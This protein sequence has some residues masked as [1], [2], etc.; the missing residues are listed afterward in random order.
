MTTTRKATWLRRLGWSLLAVLA[1]VLLLLFGARWWLLQTASGA[2][3][4]LDQAQRALQPA[5]QIERSTGNINQ[6]LRLSGVQFSNDISNTNIEQIELQARLRLLPTPQ[7]TIQQLHV[8][9]VQ[10]TVLPSDEPPPQTLPDL[11]SPIAVMVRDLRLRDVSVRLPDQNDQAEP[12]RLDSLSAALDYGDSLTVQ[13]LQLQAYAAELTVRGDAELQPPYSHDLRLDVQGAGKQ[14]LPELHDAALELRSRG[15]LEDLA[16][17]VQGRDGLPLRADVKL[18]QI[19]QQPRWELQIDSSDTLRWPLINA[20]PDATEKAAENVTDMPPLALQQ[21]QFSSSGSLDD[22][23]AELRSTVQLPIQVAGDWQIKLSGDRTQLQLESLQGSLMRGEVQAQGSYQLDPPLQ[24]GELQLQ[25]SRLQLAG[26]LDENELATALPPVSGS[27]Y[28][29]LAEQQLRLQDLLLQAADLP[30]QLRADASYGLDDDSIAS[31][32][33]WQALDWPPGS[34]ERADWHSEQGQLSASG[35]LQDLQ[36][37]LNSDV[38]G[39]AIPSAQLSLQASLVQLQSL[40]LQQLIMQT[41]GGE[42]RLSGTAGWGDGVQAQLDYQLQNIDPGQFWAGYQGNITS[43]GSLKASANADFSAPQA[44]VAINDLSG[45]LRGQPISGQGTLRYADQQFISEGLQLQSGEAKLNLHGDEKALQMMLDIPSAG[46]L[47]AAAAGS[48]KA[49][50]T[51]QALPGERL[52]LDR[53]LLQLQLSGTGLG[54]QQQN[55]EA[56]SMDADLILADAGLRGDA[57]ITLKELSNRSTKLLREASLQ[58]VSDGDGQ[59]LELSA[60]RAGTSLGLELAGSSTGP[61]GFVPWRNDFAWQGRLHDMQLQDRQLGL[62]QQATAASISYIANLL[63]LQPACLQGSDDNA[64]SSLCISSELA[65]AGPGKPF[66]IQAGLDIEQLPVAL[67]TRL[68][69]AAIT[70]NQRMSGSIKLAMA[71]QL[72]QLDASLSLEPGRL[73]LGGDSELGLSLEQG[74]LQLALT[75]DTRNGDM[76]VR[77]E[78]DGEIN[79]NWS[80]GPLPDEQPQ[81]KGDLRTRLPDL[82]LLA[83]FVPVLNE[84]AGSLNMHAQFEGP[85]PQPLIALDIDLRDGRIVYAPVGLALRDINLQGQSD[86]GQPFRGQGGLRAGDGQASMQFSLAPLKRTAELSIQGDSLQLADSQVLQLKVSPNLSLSAAPEGFTI[87]GELLIPSALLQPPKQVTSQQG[88]SADVVIVGAEQPI[89]EEQ[90][91]TNLNGKLKLVLGDD[92]RVKADVASTRLQGAV[93][94]L[95]DGEPIPQADGSIELIDGKIEAYG[96]TL[97]LRDSRVSYNESPADNPRLDIYA[98]R[99]IFGDPAVSEAGV[100]VTGRAQQPDIRLFT[101]PASNEESALAYIA[102]GSNF[103]HGNGEGA[104]N[105]GLYLFPRLFVSYGVGLFD[106]GNVTNA[107][108]ELSESWNVTLESGQRDSAVQINWRKNK[109]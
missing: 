89:A 35:T 34:G 15:D 74:E 80:Y 92:V 43:S 91:Q 7:L 77:F 13:Q 6:G 61:S 66:S 69:D 32:L 99:R 36:L 12:L 63:K 48:L 49:D 86:P 27:A 8:D 73:L 93:S 64:G 94:L 72:E 50:I 19:M 62:W 25:L 71:E 38:S 101:N 57:D 4:I 18:Y 109:D 9:G 76:L 59:R 2:G 21:L 40:Q 75:E 102:T 68:T 108:Y 105:L 45:S 10:V 104:L 26:M 30:W 37:N 46:Q 52:R 11:R 33:H 56:V 53:G 28:L 100:A 55:L 17:Q 5:L 41:L 106:N 65:S 78:Q 85:L 82:S 95:W 20:T 29:R 39:S 97:N 84:L 16:L 44:T 81:L 67:L 87:D 47:Y 31:S 107:R 90:L 24:Q 22:Y 88:E 14:L 96:Q 98:V 23:E 60:A 1:T 83:D 58:L 79:S 70:S 103:D 54:W 3:F 42:A 51:M